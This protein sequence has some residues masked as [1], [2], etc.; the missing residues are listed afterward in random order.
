MALVIVTSN[1]RQPAAARAGPGTPQQYQPA[2]GASGLQDPV[3]LAWYASSG[4]VA[5]DV[6]WA[7][8]SNGYYSYSGY[9]YGQT[10]YSLSGLTGGHTYNWQ[11]FACDYSTCVSSASWYFTMASGSSPPP[12]PQQYSPG[13]GATGLSNPVP[14]AWYQ[15]GSDTDYIVYY[16]DTSTGAGTYS[17][18][19]GMQA[20]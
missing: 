17:P 16:W 7:Y 19:L 14:F 6:A 10:S 3:T 13:Y 11:V 18:W 12:A 4:T 20:S 15:A 8:A 1:S 9:L 2:Y 5:Y